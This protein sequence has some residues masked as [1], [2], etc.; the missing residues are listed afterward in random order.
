V[1]VTQD[2][3]L[4]LAAEAPAARTIEE[5][6]E[7]LWA[8]EAALPERDGVAC[9]THLY[10]AATLNV[11]TARHRF[12][13]ERFLA[14]LEV[15]FANLF[16]DALRLS[17]TR[18][19]AVPRAWSPLFKT[20]GRRQIAKIQFALAGMNAHVNR[21]LPV[22]L[23][24]TATELKLD[25]A[26]CPGEHADYRTVNGLLAA[27]EEKIKRDLETGVAE[28][29]EDVLAKVADRIAMWD[30][31]HARE[32]AWTHAQT[33]WALRKLPPASAAFLDALDGTIGFAGRGLLVPL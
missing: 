26:D 28:E 1:A 4:R 3:R 16:F 10:L 32:T 30:V 9:F 8:I 31:V 5:V 19:A 22:A 7:R 21:D 33:L 12:L 23:V 13:D 18:P 6:V 11:K 27:T 15:V 29:V 2:E 24:R 25:F 14:R 20:R 17:V